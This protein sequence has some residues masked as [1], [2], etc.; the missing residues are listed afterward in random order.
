MDYMQAWTPSLIENHINRREAQNAKISNN[1][2]QNCCWNFDKLVLSLS[3]DDSV[4]LNLNLNSEKISLCIFQSVYILHFHFAAAAVATKMCWD[5]LQGQNPTGTC[6]VLRF[7]RGWDRMPPSNPQTSQ[8]RGRPAAEKLPR[9]LAEF[10]QIRPCSPAQKCIPT[11]RS[12]KRNDIKFV[13]E[14]DGCWGISKDKWLA[15]FYRILP[16][17]QV[18]T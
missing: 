16:H 4:N 7:L 12:E 1:W 17:I 11:L 13:F 9:F 10:D 14:G 8:H 2:K 3:L 15:E 18:K 6:W 5:F